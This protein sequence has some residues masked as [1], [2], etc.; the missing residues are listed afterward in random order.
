MNWKNQPYWEKGGK[1]TL[2]VASTCLILLF[3]EIAPSWLYLVLYPVVPI[4]YIIGFDDVL[5]IIFGVI[6]ILFIYF[7]IGAILGWLYGKFKNRN[8]PPSTL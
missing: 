4:L 7:L 1:L 5:G 2:L 3:L 8:K 6:I